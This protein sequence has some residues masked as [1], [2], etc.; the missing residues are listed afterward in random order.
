MDNKSVINAFVC[1][2]SAKSSNGNLKSLGNR[3]VSYYTT[4][5]QRL[6]NGT[7]VLNRTKYSTSTSK[8]QSWTKRVFDGHRNVVEVTNIPLGTTDLLYFYIHS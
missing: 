6:D 2:K 8:I 7:I 5:A 1:G 4:I 3:L